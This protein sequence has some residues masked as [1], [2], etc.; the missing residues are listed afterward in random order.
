MTMQLDASKPKRD[1]KRMQTEIRHTLVT[2]YGDG[3]RIA[4]QQ[5]NVRCS[6]LLHLAMDYAQMATGH[7]REKVLSIALAD[8]LATRLGGERA[9]D[10]ALALAEMLQTEVQE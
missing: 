6:A 10:M 9:P 4:R 2:R 3:D 7:D 5:F 1:T 8:Y